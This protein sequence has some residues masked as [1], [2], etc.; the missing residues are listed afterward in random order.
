[1]T[2]I[3]GRGPPPFMCSTAPRE[4]RS[5]RRLPRSGRMAQWCDDIEPTF[6]DCCFSHLLTQV[7]NKER[8]RALPLD[9]LL[10]PTRGKETFFKRSKESAIFERKT[11]RKKTALGD[12]WGVVWALV[13]VFCAF[14]IFLWWHSFFHH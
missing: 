1:M 8:A 2:S 6:P 7:R 12:V 14:M 5:S 4:A 9:P 11:N 3:L 10:Q 13:F